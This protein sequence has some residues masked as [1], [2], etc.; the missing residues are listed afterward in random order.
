MSVAALAFKKHIQASAMLQSLGDRANLFLVQKGMQLINRVPR[1]I[2]SS[3]ALV[4][5]D[6]QQLITERS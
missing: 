5:D 3:K 2:V 6:F 1:Y 4:L